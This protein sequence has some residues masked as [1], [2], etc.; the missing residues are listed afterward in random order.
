MERIEQSKITPE[1]ISQIRQIFAEEFEGYITDP[2]T[3]GGTDSDR[4]ILDKIRAGDKL[5]SRGTY[6]EDMVI[7]IASKRFK[8]WQEEDFKKVVDEFFE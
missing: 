3:L 7:G 5:N 1:I 2:R 6:L 8:I 4:Q